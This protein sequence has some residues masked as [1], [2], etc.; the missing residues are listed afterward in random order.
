MLFFIVIELCFLIR[1]YHLCLQMMLLIFTW[2]AHLFLDDSFCPSVFSS[3]S[4][5]LMLSL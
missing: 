5:Y 2:A 3:L 4:I 1:H